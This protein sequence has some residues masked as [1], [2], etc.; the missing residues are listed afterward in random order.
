MLAGDSRRQSHLSFALERPGDLLYR[1][2]WLLDRPVRVEELQLKLLVEEPPVLL[3]PPLLYFTDLREKM[4]YSRAL[5]NIAEMSHLTNGVI[6]RPLDVSV[7]GSSM[8]LSFEPARYFDYLDS[9][10]V[11]ELALRERFVD[12]DRH[13]SSFHLR[14]CIAAMGI[15]TLVVYVDA[16]GEAKFI[17]HRRN[18]DVT[19]GGNT[20]HVVPAGEFAP[21]NTD[22]QSLLRD[23]NIKSNIEREF[24]EEIFGQADGQDLGSAALATVS[25]VGATLRESAGRDKVEY[26]VLGIGLHP[27]TLKPDLLT[28]AIFRDGLFEEFRQSIVASGREGSIIMDI[29]FSA[30]SIQRFS[31]EPRTYPSAMA[32]LWKAWAHRRMLRV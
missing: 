3:D 22:A 11:Y 5:V 19:V 31:R 29:P 16:C 28:V 4:S 12:S 32:C 1:E 6:Y 9:M 26:H 24:S 2:D 21:A 27:A 13:E 18:S 14:D 20:Y 10:A 23:L 8:S 30:A 25:A 17:M 15:V 7:S